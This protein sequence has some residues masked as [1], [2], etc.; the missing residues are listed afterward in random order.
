MISI[1]NTTFNIK[2]FLPYAHALY[3]GI[4]YGYQNNLQLSPCT[5]F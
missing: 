2:K 5:S 3:L 1:W 4:L